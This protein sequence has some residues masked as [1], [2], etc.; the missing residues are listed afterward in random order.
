MIRS[1]DVFNSLKS[2]PIVMG[3]ID[4]RGNLVGQVIHEF[5]RQWRLRL[6]AQTEQK[7][8]RAVQ[9]EV[10]YSSFD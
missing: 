8:F 2:F 5:S 6:Q 4:H 10:C 9:M 3:D 1:V 7:E